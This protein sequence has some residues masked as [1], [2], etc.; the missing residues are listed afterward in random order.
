MLFCFK[1][2]KT[3]FRKERDDAMASNNYIELYKV[4]LASWVEKALDQSLTKKKHFVRV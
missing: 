4:T 2:Y 1:S 3:T